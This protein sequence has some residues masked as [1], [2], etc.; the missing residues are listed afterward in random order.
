MGLPGLIDGSLRPVQIGLEHL[1]HPVV[2]LI[3]IFLGGIQRQQR[4]RQMFAA[5]GVCKS[6]AGAVGR[7]SPGRVGGIDG[8]QLRTLHLAADFDS[9]FRVLLPVADHTSLGVICTALVIIRF[10]YDFLNFF[11]RDTHGF[12]S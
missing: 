3:S 1:R 4:R 12:N 11:F 9:V 5:M 8:V 6:A 7:Q 10:R 2:A